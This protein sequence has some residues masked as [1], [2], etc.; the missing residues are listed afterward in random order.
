MGSNL[1]GRKALILGAA[2]GMGK[3]VALPY[4]RL[5]TKDPQ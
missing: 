5:T 1:Q 3:A 4:L 2:G